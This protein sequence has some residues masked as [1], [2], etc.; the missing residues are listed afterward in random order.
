MKSRIVEVS[1]AE[2]LTW[3]HGHSFKSR[4]RVWL[5]VVGLGFLQQRKLSY[6][7]FALQTMTKYQTRRPDQQPKPGRS[8]RSRATG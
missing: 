5:Q 8:N 7:L 2:G 3:R 6:N 4:L 1:K